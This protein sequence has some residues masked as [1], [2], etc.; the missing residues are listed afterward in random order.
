MNLAQKNSADYFKYGL[1]GTGQ[2]VVKYPQLN[3]KVAQ[4]FALGSPIAM[5]L[6]VRGIDKLGT[7]FK[8]PTCPEFFNVFHPFDPVAYRFEPLICSDAVLRPILM[9]H[10]KGRKRMHLELRENLTKVSE[11]LKQRMYGQINKA[12]SSLAEFAKLPKV[13][14]PSTSN[15]TSSINSIEQQQTPLSSSELQQN[16]DMETNK[17]I[18]EAMG[19]SE[20]EHINEETKVK[21]NM[22]KV[23]QGRRVDYVLQERPIEMFNEYLFALASHACYW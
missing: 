4:F 13:L 15:T 2:L 17:I 18:D 3:F 21:V 6:T 8:F 10:H 1:A 12:W 20:Q 7:D 23:N 16:S 11:D 19:T 9:P 22:G 14:T 5:F